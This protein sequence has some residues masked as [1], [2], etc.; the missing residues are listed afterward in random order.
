MAVV[1]WGSPIPVNCGGGGAAATT[2]LSV[3]H[4]CFRAR[5]PFLEIWDLEYLFSF[6]KS[7]MTVSSYFWMQTC[8]ILTPEIFVGIPIFRYSRRMNFIVVK[9][10]PKKI[11]NIL[12]LSTT[13][14]IG[15]FNFDRNFPLVLCFVSLLCFFLCLLLYFLLILSSETSHL[16]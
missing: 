12:Y 1:A 7:L 9:I 3:D 16:L 13:V 15:K 8:V 4:Y 11:M 2:I 14:Y 5:K 6:W 10:Y